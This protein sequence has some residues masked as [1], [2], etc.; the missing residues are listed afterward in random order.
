MSCSVYEWG[1][2]AGQESALSPLFSLGLNPLMS[3]NSNFSGSSGFFGS[4]AKFSKIHEFGVMRSLLAVDQSLSG[5]KNYC[6]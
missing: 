2:A 3:G 5:E 6:I 4:F 1:L